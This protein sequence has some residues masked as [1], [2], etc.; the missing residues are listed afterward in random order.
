MQHFML[1]T[2][3]YAPVRLVVQHQ[4]AEEYKNCIP[5]PFNIM[6]NVQDQLYTIHRQKVQIYAVISHMHDSGRRTHFC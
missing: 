1:I 4:K 5:Y 3:Q 6:S 2:L